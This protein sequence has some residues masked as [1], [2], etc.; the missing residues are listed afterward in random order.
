MLGSTDYD[1]NKDSCLRSWQAYSVSLS[2]TGSWVPDGRPQT[3]DFEACASH[4]QIPGQANLDNITASHDMLLLEASI[5]DTTFAAI[6]HA[7]IFMPDGKDWG[8]AYPDSRGQC[9]LELDKA[10]A[11]IGNNNSSKLVEDV[12]AKVNSIFESDKVKPKP[13]FQLFVPGYLQLFYEDGGQGDWCNNTSFSLRRENRPFLSLD[14]RAEINDIVREVN[15]AVEA[16]VATSNHADQAHFVDLDSQIDDQRF[17]QPSHTLYDQYYGDKVMFWN[18]APEGVILRSKPANSDSKADGMYEVRDPTPNEFDR[19]L[20]TGS[21]TTD[22]REVR[23]NMTVVAGVGLSFAEGNGIDDNTKWLNQMG[24]YRNLPGLALRTFH[25]KSAGHNAIANVISKEIRYRY[26]HTSSNTG[27]QL[28]RQNPNNKYSLQILMREYNGYFSWFMYQGPYGFAVNPC[29]DKKFK[30]VANDK[31]DN[32][33][34]LS[35]MKPPFVAPGQNWEVKIL[36]YWNCRFESAQDGPGTL[37]CGEP[38]SLW[39]DFEPEPFPGNIIRCATTDGFPDGSYH[40]AWVV[41]Y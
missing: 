5:L 24:P 2:E 40:R 12:R 7:C 41:E 4:T 11:Y 10:R 23:T 8:A 19:W 9:R 30:I 27:D 17:C 21:F 25:P 39:Y 22:T 16:G 37:K 28:N 29:R 15:N 13:D 38:P 35:L 26:A 6:A 34:G 20:E 33:K 1:G 36:D 3:F 31:R 18:L 32:R 14:L